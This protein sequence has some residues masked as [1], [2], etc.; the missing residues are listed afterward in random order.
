MRGT[1]LAKRLEGR[2][3]AARWPSAPAPPNEFFCGCML[4]AC[5]W[6]GDAESEDAERPVSAGASRADAA[7]APV[8]GGGARCDNDTPGVESEAFVLGLAS[9][10]IGSGGG[11]T[12]GSTPSIRMNTSPRRSFVQNGY[13]CISNKT[14]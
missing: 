12:E 1:F 5:F 7:V 6:A 4:C 2:A 10:A 8:A 14:S 9:L 3:A 13:K 11:R